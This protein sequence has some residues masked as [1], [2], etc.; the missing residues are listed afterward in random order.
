MTGKQLLIG[1]TQE[2]F[3]FFICGHGD[4]DEIAAP[5]IAWHQQPHDDAV[6]PSTSYMIHRSG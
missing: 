4:D 5:G 3:P 6:P 1:E 2:M